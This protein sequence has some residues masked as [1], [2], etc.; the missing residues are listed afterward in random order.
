MTYPPT[1]QMLPLERPPERV[2]SVPGSKSITNRALVLAALASPH[3]GRSE[4]VLENALHAE[5]T[6]VMVSA[7]RE[8]GIPVATNWPAGRITVP[9]IPPSDW[10][11]EANLFCGN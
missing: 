5:D 11:P 2:V 10:K 8:L 4:S 7:L 9:C 1:Y 6:E 3:D